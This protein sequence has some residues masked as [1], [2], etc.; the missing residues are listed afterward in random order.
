[1]FPAGAIIKGGRE[2][3]C[4]ETQHFNLP[5]STPAAGIGGAI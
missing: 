1:M 3:G 4:L 2:G 5:S